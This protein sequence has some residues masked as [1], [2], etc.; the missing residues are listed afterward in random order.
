MS[1][2][3]VV[4]KAQS[5]P[6]AGNTETEILTLSSVKKTKNKNIHLY[7]VLLVLLTADNSLTALTSTK[8]FLH[9]LFKALIFHLKR[10]IMHVDHKFDV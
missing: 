2:Y 3:R 8:L 7:A 5:Y 1:L 6:N 9:I 10:Q 4:I